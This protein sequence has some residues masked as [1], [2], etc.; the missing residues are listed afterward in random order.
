MGASQV[1]SEIADNE[2]HMTPEQMR[3][4]IAELEAAV[5]ELESAQAHE[6]GLADGAELR[7]GQLEMANSNLR[8]EIAMN[9]R[10][11]GEFHVQWRNLLAVLDNFTEI[12][13][14]SDPRTHEI[15]FVNRAFCKQLGGDP[16]GGKCFEQFRGSVRPL[17]ILQQRNASPNP[18]ALYLG[19]LQC[20]S[21]QAFH[22]Q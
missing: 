7:T 4:R 22:D 11:A 19:A 21:E 15:I 8:M 5:R 2:T 10:P 6:R 9:R 20:Q 14:V 1:T 12:L 3:A 13:Y 17:S 18:S 16:V